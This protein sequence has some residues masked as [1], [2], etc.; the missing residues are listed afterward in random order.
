MFILLSPDKAVCSLVKVNEFI[1]FWSTEKCAMCVENIKKY[2]YL[3]RD[4]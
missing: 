4:V 2:L 1:W 3:S